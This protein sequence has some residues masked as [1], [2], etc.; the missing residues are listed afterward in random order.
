MAGLFTAP[1]VAL[2]SAPFLLMLVLPVLLAV[3]GCLYRSRVF[4]KRWIPY[5]IC[6]YALWLAELHRQDLS[7]LRN[8]SLLLVL[9]FFAICE[10]VGTRAL[11][12]SAAAISLGTVLLG[13]TDLNGTLYLHHPVATRRG[14]LLA[15]QDD[16]VMN[17][18]LS[19]TQAGDYVFVYPYAPIYYYLAALRN[20]TPLNVIVDQRETRPI[21]QSIQGLEAKKPRF[22][23]QETKLLGDRMR[24]L[25]PG[26]KPPPPAERVIDRYVEAHYHP[27]LSVE[28]FKILERNLE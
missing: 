16:A 12:I 13:T 22:V 27:V 23:V 6:G 9:L 8:G 17:F 2:M 19:H 28:D 7:H 3:L 4:E 5:W 24:T 15:R 25:F 20:P 11:R 21:R 18:L 10:R 1:T 26:F 14:T